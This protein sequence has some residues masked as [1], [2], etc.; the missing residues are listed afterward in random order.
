[1]P[2]AHIIH[3]GSAATAGKL[4]I[5][6]NAAETSR[7]RGEWPQGLCR[8]APRPGSA[9]LRWM[10]EPE[11]KAALWEA[12]CTV[13][14]QAVGRLQDAM[15]AAATTVLKIMVDPNAPTGT[16]LRAAE[17]VLEQGARE[18][19]DIE[20]RV[21]ELERTVSLPQEIAQAFSRSHLVERHAFTRSDYN[22]GADRC[23]VPRQRGDR[24]GCRRVTQWQNRLS[25]RQT[26]RWIR[27]AAASPC[28][29]LRG[30]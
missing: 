21:T 7:Q 2:F 18:M 16:R 3:S 12:R 11:F 24:R 14:S 17:I 28:W 13:A 26:N 5:K 20:D 19:E 15:G 30:D 22:A 8:K 27:P 23:A 4:A 6:K 9:L 25:H 29:K 1:M 10:K